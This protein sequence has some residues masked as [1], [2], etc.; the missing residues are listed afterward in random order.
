MGAGG[1]DNF[2]WWLERGL[3]KI[4]KYAPGSAA[5]HL[6]YLQ[7]DGSYY[8]PPDKQ[9]L[10]PEQAMV[11]IAVAHATVVGFGARSDFMA[12]D[13]DEFVQ[14]NRSRS[15][16]LLNSYFSEKFLPINSMDHLSRWLTMFGVQP[17]EVPEGPVARN[18]LLFSLYEMLAAP[19]AWT[20]L[21]FARLLYREFPPFGA[22]VGEKHDPSRDVIDKPAERGGNGVPAARVSD[23]PNIPRNL[24]IYG[25][26]GTGKT[27]RLLREIAPQFGDRFEMVTFHPGCAYEEFVEALRPVSDG[28]N[29]PVRYDVV[30][31]IF[32]RACERASAEPEAPFLLAIDEIN[33][34]NLANVLGELITLIEEDKRGNGARVTLPYSKLP[35]SVPANLW[36][37][38]TMNTADRSI[39]LMDI[40]LRRRFIFEELMVDY[41][42]L[43]EDFASSSDPQLNGIDLARILYSMNRRL[44]LLLDR[45][46]QIGHAWLFGIRSLAD[47]RARFAQ[48]IL[49]LLAEYFF[50]DWSRA[51]LVL[52]EDPKTA[53]GTDLI[54]KTSM[55]PQDQQRVLGRIVRDGGDFCLYDQ[56]KPASWGVAHFAKIAGAGAERPVEHA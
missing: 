30:P 42:A 55:K 49:P 29:G 34:A 25:P 12:A 11:D 4:G 1:Q 45:D 40:A 46:H 13:A 33:R 18:H 16:K 43:A 2:C 38:G 52:G 22:D 54:V 47:L 56:G 3:E 19:S 41:D 32:R 36:V 21:D 20:P 9:G 5:G 23:G 50:D 44:Q 15:L 17:P 8:L 37:V 14:K 10:S 35:F 53:A 31:G 51:A 24:I 7:K 28:Q 26:P 27:R 6:I 48:R 39:A